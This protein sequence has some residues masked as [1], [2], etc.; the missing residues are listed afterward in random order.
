MVLQLLTRACV[1][2][3]AQFLSHTVVCRLVC[4]FVYDEE[5]VDVEVVDH[6]V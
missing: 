3:M 1:W 6:L 2:M 5:L 4:S